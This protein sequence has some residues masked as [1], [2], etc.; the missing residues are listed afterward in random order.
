MS[1]TALSKMTDHNIIVVDLPARKMDCSN[2]CLLGCKRTIMPSI[3]DTVK[4]G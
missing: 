1:L 2:V 3:E 4:L